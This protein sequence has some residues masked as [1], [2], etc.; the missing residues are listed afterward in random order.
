M[1]G[2]CISNVRPIYMSIKGSDE[3]LVKRIAAEQ[4]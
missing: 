3:A 2:L 4:R 1:E